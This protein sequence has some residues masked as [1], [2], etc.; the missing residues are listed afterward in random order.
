ME[1]GKN[2]EK[3][4]SSISNAN[5]YEEIGEFWDEHDTAECWEDTYPVEF[6]INLKD[7]EDI[8]YRAFYFNRGNET[9]Q[10]AISP[11]AEI[12]GCRIDIPSLLILDIANSLIGILN[13][14]I[15]EIK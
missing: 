10:I 12:K 4:K 7:D 3:V 14:I 2:I 9:Y 13:N 15:T 6:T 8:V 11:S 5:S 1:N